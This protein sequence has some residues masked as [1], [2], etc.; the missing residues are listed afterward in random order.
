MAL[1]Q[2]QLQVA[3]LRF[4]V[5]RV[6]LEGAFE[7]GLVAGEL[8]FGREVE[9]ADQTGRSR[10]GGVVRAELASAGQDRRGLVQLAFLG[11][12]AAEVEQDAGVAGAAADAWRNTGTASEARSSVSSV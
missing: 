9:E 11:E 5:V 7:T 10:I 4:G 3:D 1:A 8:L 2:Q 12:S 6:L